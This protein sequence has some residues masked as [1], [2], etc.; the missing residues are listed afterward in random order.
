LEKYIEKYN[1]VRP[2]SLLRFHCS[3]GYRTPTE[4]AY[5]YATINSN[6][7]KELRGGP[8]I[9]CYNFFVSTCSRRSELIQCCYINK[10]GLL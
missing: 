4:V 5:R 7:Y 8:M 1:F 6:S 10:N 2:A 3:L 9:M